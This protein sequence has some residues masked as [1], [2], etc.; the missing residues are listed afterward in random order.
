MKLLAGGSRVTPFPV[1]GVDSEEEG[2]T[3]AMLREANRLKGVW[4][5]CTD[6]G[7]GVLGMV[8]CSKEGQAMLSVLRNHQD[9]RRSTWQQIRACHPGVQ[10]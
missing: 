7:E 5:T 10:P 9:L 3:E 1:C 8:C 6:V 2:S 4:N